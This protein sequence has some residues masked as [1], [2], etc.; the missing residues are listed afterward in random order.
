[1]RRIVLI[2]LITGFQCAPLTAAEV[3]EDSVIAF[4]RVW[5][6]A[7]FN[8]VN[9]SRAGYGRDQLIPN[10]A[11]SQNTPMVQAA[12]R[13]LVDRGIEAA[14]L[15]LDATTF[16]FNEGPYCQSIARTLAQ[17]EGTRYYERRR[18]SGF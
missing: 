11:K 4:C 5:Q 9:D 7:A 17:Y 16:A 3:N 18:R 10:Y 13:D 2:A 15:G 6:Q 12:L 1:M 8:I 14:R